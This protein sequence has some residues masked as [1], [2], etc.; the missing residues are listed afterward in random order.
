MRLCLVFAL[1]A[2]TLA[3]CTGGSDPMSAGATAKPASLPGSPQTATDKRLNCEV[4]SPTGQNRCVEITS[5]DGATRPVPVTKARQTA[6]TDRPL[7]PSDCTTKGLAAYGLMAELGNRWQEWR[8]Y[9]DRP[10]VLAVTEPQNQP[11]T[12]AAK[13]AVRGDAG[14]RAG[15]WYCD[16]SVDGAGNYG[17]W[18]MTKDPARYYNCK[19]VD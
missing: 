9:C 15:T 14:A 5:K 6:G 7:V 10:D 8:A 17:T 3:G 19:R 11:P 2:L 13:A 4:K 1:S 16:D 18:E 12:A